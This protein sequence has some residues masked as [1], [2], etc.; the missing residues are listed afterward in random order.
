V[1]VVPGRYFV[2]G[3]QDSSHVRLCVAGIGEQDIPT[4]VAL[5]AEAVRASADSVEAGAMLG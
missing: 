1:S 5:L 3:E 4:A 2:V